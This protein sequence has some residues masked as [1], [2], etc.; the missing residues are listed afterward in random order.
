MVKQGEIKQS[1]IRQRQTKPRNPNGVEAVA[2]L[3]SG[4]K[5]KRIVV[6][7]PEG[8]KAS[9]GTV[10]LLREFADHGKR[11]ILVDMTAQGTVG[12]AMLDGTHLPGITDLLSGERRFNEVIHSDRFSQAHVVP[13]GEA[14][15]EAA[16][17]SADRLPLILDAL[18]TVYDF[19]VVE[20]GPSSSEQ[21]RRIADGSAAVVMSIV[22]PD[23]K[24]VALAAL[25]LD[26]GGYEDVV[27]LMDETV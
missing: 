21:I 14:D 27:I 22:D 8:D 5:L 17:R 4:G 24:G 10:R 18:E 11:A 3:L 26:Q 25:D 20:C 6:V 7:S 15:P 2:D 9:A 12:L 16:M 1:E 13:L 19:V 23:D